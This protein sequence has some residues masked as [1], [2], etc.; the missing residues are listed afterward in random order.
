MMY[1]SLF[2]QELDAIP[3]STVD[4]ERVV[5]RRRRRQRARTVLAATTGIV[6]TA[7]LVVLTVRASPVADGPAERFGTPGGSAL[8]SPSNDPVAVRLAAA[9]AGYLDGTVPGV[10]YRP[11]PLSFTHQVKEAKP[12]IPGVQGAQQGEDYYYVA[13][14][15]ET[16]AGI[17]SIAVG[18][19]RSGPQLL[20]LTGTCPAEAPL[21][22][23]EWSCT[24]DTGPRGERIAVTEDRGTAAVR[25][26]V[27]AVRPDGTAVFVEVTNQSGQH[28][29]AEF[30]GGRRDSPQPPLTVTGARDLALT[31]ALTV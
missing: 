4:V 14:D 15:A 2:D 7:G 31:P 12:E 29:S 8:P 13:A 3:P 11:A 5:R 19:G 1:R 21:D 17:G 9:L 30:D 6:V 26:R 16:D 28:R 10:R 23:A 20:E 27:E 22:A 24:P 25:Y 18:V